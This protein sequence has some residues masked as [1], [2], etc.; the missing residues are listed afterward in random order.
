MLAASTLSAPAS[1]PDQIE[2]RPDP[3]GPGSGGDEGVVEEAESRILI[4]FE[5][6]VG[7]GERAEAREEVDAA[8]VRSYS[9][10][11]RL[12]LIELPAGRDRAE[13]IEA[14][15]AD[16]GVAYAEPDIVRQTQVTSPNDTFYRSPNSY[17]WGLNN[18][19]QSFTA[20]STSYTGT[21]DADIDAPE[22][23]DLSRGSA[24]VTVAVIDSGIQLNHPD[25]A[26][27]IW[28]NPGEVAGNGIDD[29]GN[30]R[31]DDVNGWD[32][33]NN[34]NNPTDDDG[35]GTHVAGTIGAV[36][37]N[38]SG[39][40]GVAWNVK[41]MP[42]KACNA[43]GSCPI[44]ATIAALNYA[45]AQ[46]VNISN[47]S[48][49]GIGSQN[50][51][52]R[53]A[54]TAARDAG[55]LYVAAAGNDGLNTDLSGNAHYPSN[56]T[57][58]NI[59]SVASTTLTD[60][61][62]SFSNYGTTSVD[63]GAPGSQ[64]ISTY[65]TSSYAWS[66]GTSMASPHVAGVA[67][68]IKARKP[69]WTYS[70]IRSRLLDNTRPIA[71][72]AGR[73]VTGGMLNAFDA[74][75]FAPEPPS[76]TAGPS[77]FVAS[78]SA[79]LA[80]TGETVGA[81]VT[82]ECQIDSGSWGSC[83]SPR[84]YTS[85]S[86]GSHTFEVRQTDQ[87]GNVS[88]AASRNWT[89]DTVAPS[90]PSI[91]SGPSGFVSSA[92]ASFSFTGEAS[93]SFECRIDAGSWESC[94]SPKSYSGLAEGSHTFEVRQTDQAG[95]T[96]TATSQSWTVDTVAP[97]APTITSGPSGTVDL[98]EATFEFSGEPSATFECQIDSGSWESCSSPKAYSGLSE[99]AHTF[100]VRQ[101]DQAGNV[102]SPAS[103][104][105]TVDLT[106]SPPSIDSG[107]S[108]FL[109][110]ASAS[111]SFTGEAFATFEC[112]L[113][114]GIWEACSSP[115][116]Y[117][118]LPEGPHTF[119][120]R[121]TDTS[122]LTSEPSSRTWTVDTVAPAAPSIT[123]GP[124]GSSGSAE[125]TFTFSG[126][127]EATF[128]CRLD[129][130]A[131]TTCVSPKTFSS[132]GEGPHTFEVRQTDRAGNTSAEASR[133]WD[134]ILTVARPEITSGP[135]GSVNSTS[136]TFEFTGVEGATFRCRIDDS[137]LQP[138]SSPF[139]ATGLSAGSHEFGV[140]QTDTLGNTSQE[141]VRSW[142]VL[143][144]AVIEPSITG[145]DPTGAIIFEGAPE[146]FTYLCAIGTEQ[147]HPCSS[148]Y[149]PVGLTDGTY[150]ITVVV[151][152]PEGNLS[153]PLET[154]LVVEGAPAPSGEEPAVILNGGATYARKATVT[155]GL[156]W[157][158]GARTALITNSSDF[159]NPPASL[160][161][162]IS[163]DLTPGQGS[164]KVTVRLLGA[165]DT[166]LSTVSDTI[167]LDP[168]RPNLKSAK[169][170]KQKGRVWWTAVKA[171]DS[172]SG[173]SKL[174][175]LT[176]RSRPGADTKPTKQVK[177][178]KSTTVKTKLP[179]RPRWVT[180]QDRAGNWSG[181]KAVKAP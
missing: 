44:S 181:W 7:P 71:A 40:T 49:G 176:R 116:A 8:F 35:H 155:L 105:W 173:L 30:G 37:N 153:V 167:F 165:G 124:S 113:D 31:I 125:A 24:G 3:A 157:P 134:V 101:T 2:T 10:V 48:Y 67:A 68:L 135:E 143:E 162:S 5:P 28:T 133:T 156:V 83:T 111:F 86:Q 164:K 118:D 65:P 47:N 77:G 138:C 73:S 51:A 170:R 144:V 15:E 13:A 95:N 94:S 90:A 50:T 160:S 129:E 64:I 97:D 108:G 179:S 107:P 150:P 146:G 142:T 169:I 154:D 57:M 132:L 25:L 26:A 56:Y 19:G 22:A 33:I 110:S 9:L 159:P 61:L 145:V 98:E 120:V 104:T 139:E 141:E 16:P 140:E 32:F 17:L 46:G 23:W 39:V 29:D 100:E 171:G 117:S 82:F 103:R 63:L 80:F 163:W 79:S 109:S 93:A 151:E 130:A 126:E 122:E 92:S 66:N 166:P 99:G 55:H 102:S 115:K 152:D 91:T 41:L 18:T 69:T 123:S 175:L 114:S 36:G 20:G 53:N 70:Q 74:L 59:V 4:R 45:V 60:G 84:S 87:A 88:T 6:G 127:P 38:N 112:R 177:F 137:P 147:L 128:E 76:I 106:P 54:I 96:S 78:T 168:N 178:V 149:A 131:W 85:L 27:N 119:E 34:D 174:A 11:P 136:A 1:R 89:V 81:G 72:L 172:G 161:E 12:Q 21:P 43:T 42:V 180:V 58:D 52:E 14:L 62:S 148:P 121:Q 75:D 158:A